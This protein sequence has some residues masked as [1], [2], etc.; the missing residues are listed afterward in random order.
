MEGL[1]SHESENT[2]K[3]VTDMDKNHKISNTLMHIKLNKNG[4]WITKEINVI[5]TLYTYYK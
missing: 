1:G 4:I 5:D 2:G 3:D